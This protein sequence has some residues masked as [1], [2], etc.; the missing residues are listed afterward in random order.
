MTRRRAMNAS[1]KVCENVFLFP[2]HWSAINQ[3][4]AWIYGVPNEEVDLG[5]RRTVRLAA[6]KY[7]TLPPG[8][9]RMFRSHYFPADLPL[10]LDWLRLIQDLAVMSEMF[11]EDMV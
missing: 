10:R 2:S 11:G 4:A 7:R 5:M 3:T 6:L 9:E 1:G 8:E